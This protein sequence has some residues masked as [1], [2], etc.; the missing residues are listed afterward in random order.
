M[1]EKWMERLDLQDEAVPGQSLIEII[2]CSRVLI[3]RHSGVCAYGSRH[4]AVRVP[5]GTVSI[6]GECLELKKMDRGQLVICGRI[7]GIC[8]E[9]N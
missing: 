6:N 8:I 9:R 4:I 3:E 5:F 7:E 2:G 1:L